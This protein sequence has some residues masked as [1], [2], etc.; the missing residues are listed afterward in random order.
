MDYKLLLV[1]VSE[2]LEHALGHVA[3][4]EGCYQ[5]AARQLEVVEERPRVHELHHRREHV[6]VCAEEHLVAPHDRWVSQ[7]VVHFR[8]RLQHGA[9]LLRCRQ[10][11]VLDGHLHRILAHCALPCEHHPAIPLADHPVPRDV[12]SRVRVFLN[13]GPGRVRP[14]HRASPRALDGAGGR[15][16]GQ[17][18]IVA[19]VRRRWWRTVG[20]DRP[21]VAGRRAG[22]DVDGNFRMG[23]PFRLQGR[24]RDHR[25]ARLPN[26]AALARC[27]SP[28]L[29]HPG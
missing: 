4:R 9:V 11:H 23:A 12:A 29:G 25:E 26:P 2:G 15:G 18:V 10:R 1:E 27:G 8:L 7:V 24:L 5:V 3:Q 20:R 28:G 6:L 22:R 21:R 14:R 13:L 17:L 16:H 19:V